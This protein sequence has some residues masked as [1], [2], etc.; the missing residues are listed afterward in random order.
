MDVIHF[1]T[2][3]GRD[4]SVKLFGSVHCPDTSQRADATLVRVA[5]P[6]NAAMKSGCITTF[7]R[8]FISRCHLCSEYQ[9]GASAILHKILRYRNGTPSVPASQGGPC[10][11]FAARRTTPP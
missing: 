6:A 8:Y 3:S 4:K 2:L 5:P 11:R 9:V 10:A 7:R 1:A